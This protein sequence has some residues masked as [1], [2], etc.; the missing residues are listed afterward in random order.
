MDKKKLPIGYYLK[1]ADN[2]LTESINKIHSDFGLTRTEW[3]ILNSI[4]DGVDKNIILSQLSEFASIGQLNEL[5]S[6]LT[7]RKLVIQTPLLKLTDKGEEIFKKCLQK[8][9][10]FR[11]KSMQ[12]ISEKEYSQLIASLEKI[13]DNL[14]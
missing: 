4:N 8:Q 13:I 11:Q 7:T 9:T 6:E 3:Q 14:K 10:V 2:L 12:N 5:I 1:K